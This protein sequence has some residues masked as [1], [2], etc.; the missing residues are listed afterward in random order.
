MI[1]TLMHFDTPL[2]TFSAESK[3][4][5]DNLLSAMGLSVNRPFDL[6]RISKGLST[7]T[8][9]QATRKNSKISQRSLKKSWENNV[10]Y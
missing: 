4:E 1:Y 3:A 5:A 8:N 7:N 6:L 10:M 2:I 9:L